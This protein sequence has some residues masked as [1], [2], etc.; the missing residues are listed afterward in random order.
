MAYPLKLKLFDYEYDLTTESLEPVAITELI[1]D[2]VY[3]V[4]SEVLYDYEPKPNGHFG[5]HGDYAEEAYSAMRQ[6][7]DANKENT[8]LSV[9]LD[10]GESKELA[11]DIPQM[12]QGVITNISESENFGFNG[13][14]FKTQSLEKFIEQGSWQY[15]LKNFA[16]KVIFDSSVWPKP[17]VDNESIIWKDDTGEYL[18][19]IWF[20]LLDEEPIDCWSLCANA[21][22]FNAAEDRENW[23]YFW[24][25][26]DWGIEEDEWYY[27]VE[28]GIYYPAI[29]PVIQ[30]CPIALSERDSNEDVLR[31]VEQYVLK[32]QIATGE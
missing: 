11:I 8:F 24:F 17:V 26:E 2:Y 13:L 3:E 7:I 14:S 32:K 5:W 19:I 25:N 1:Q 6:Y 4:T 21:E 23:Q 10:N 9:L 31:K 22:L 16:N 15:G 12:M 30:S 18:P 20:G 29:E 28:G 27:H